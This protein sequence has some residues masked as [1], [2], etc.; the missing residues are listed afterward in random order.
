MN[1][2]DVLRGLKACREATSVPVMILSAKSDVETK[3]TGLRLGATDF[4][5]K[6]FAMAE[7]LARRSM[8]RIRSLHEQ[9]RRAQ[10][11]LE[12]RSV[13]DA[14]TGLK[15][16]RFFDERLYEE[17]CRAHQ[18]ADPV[19]LIMIDVDHFKTVNDRYGHPAGATPCCA[20]RRP[21]CARRSATPTSAAGTAARSS[22]SSSRR[23]TCRAHSRSPS[24]SGARWARSPTRSRRPRQ[25]APPRSV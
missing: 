25:A 12:E 23:P 19:S 22:R 3:V 21:S 24:G 4:M 5:A 15:N 6:P 18:Y 8:L 2:L 11:G 14:L 16:R 9:L 10:R 1:G 17:F 7:V 20:R 13:T